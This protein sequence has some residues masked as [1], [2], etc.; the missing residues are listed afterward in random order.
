MGVNRGLNTQHVI[1]GIG[2]RCEG[3]QNQWKMKGGSAMARKPVTSNAART[4][5]GTDFGGSRDSIHT[6]NNLQ[7]DTHKQ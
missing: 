4:R 3:R 7:T 1:D 6:N 5:R 2:T